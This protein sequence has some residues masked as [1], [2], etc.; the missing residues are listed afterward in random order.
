M[1][2]SNESSTYMTSVGKGGRAGG[3]SKGLAPAHFFPLE[4]PGIVYS[5]YLKNG[6]SYQKN[7]PN[8]RDRKSNFLSDVCH[9]IELISNHYSSITIS[10]KQTQ[11]LK[12]TSISQ[13]RWTLSKT[14]ME[15]KRCRIQF[16][17]VYVYP[18]L[19]MLIRS[20]DITM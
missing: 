4:G 10:K 1:Y 19:S 12:Q 13:K 9:Q 5:K 11:K 8:E 14:C 7:A 6:E 15:Q 18:C 17:H 2:S 20:L 3:P 16:P